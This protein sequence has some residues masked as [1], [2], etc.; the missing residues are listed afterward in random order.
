MT[1]TVVVGAVLGAAVAPAAAHLAVLTAQQRI[2]HP[3]RIRAVMVVLAGI[4]GGVAAA[5]QGLPALAA[6]LPALVPAAAAAA[7]DA[8][9]RRLPD[10][11]TGA[12]AIVVAVQAVV[13]L[14]LDQAG[15]LRAAWV[16]VGGAALCLLAKALLPDTVGWGD[17]KFAPSLAALLVAHGWPALYTGLLTWCGLVLATA[18]LDLA[19]RNTGGVVAYGPALVTGTAFGMIS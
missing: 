9:E 10:P 1:A 5:R 14:V 11:L 19:R 18:L 15:G 3:I 13:L 17:V 6:V 7:V 16:F 8:N 4:F 12:V 2:D